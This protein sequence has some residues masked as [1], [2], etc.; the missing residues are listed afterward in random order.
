MLLVAPSYAQRPDFSAFEQ[1]IKQLDDPNWKTRSA[2]FYALL[3]L[4]GAG[5][6]PEDA[7]SR[8][9]QKWPERSD[10]IKLAL[11]KL[12]QK[13][14]ALTKERDD[15]ILQKY[16]KEGGNFLHPFPDAE[17]RSAYYPDVIGV[18]TVLK[19]PRAI[20][21]LI[22]AI[23]TGGMVGTALVELGDAAVDRVIGVL[24]SGEVVARGAATGILADMLD[25]K[26]AH[27]VTDP[28]SRR[29]I[30]EALTRAAR[31]PNQRIRDFAHEALKKLR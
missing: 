28:G 1:S 8:L 24:D 29:K 30:T 5:A 4:G 10:Q 27:R 23:E 12:L 20:D 21:A 19:D 14:N 2:A 15:L 7:L 6:E 9:L 22:G 18:V 11:I 17:E 25:T 31:D 13:E 16:A 26:N 3:T